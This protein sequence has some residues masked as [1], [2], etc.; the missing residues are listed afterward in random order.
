MQTKSDYG[1]RMETRSDCP[2]AC[3]LDLIGDR[4]SLLI[5]RALFIGKRRY[6]EFL[7]MP[8]KISTNILANRLAALI[9]NGIID[10]SAYSLR[11]ARYE[12]RLTVK[13]A[14]LLGVMQQMTGWAE[15]HLPGLAMPP[16]SFV[17][18]SAAEFYP[19]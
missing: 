10:R 19:K 18:A 17:M 11:P 4:W 1:L 6:G 5:L 8:E 9:D 14:D 12:Y 2:I 7:G 15:K 16:E 3:T 13:G